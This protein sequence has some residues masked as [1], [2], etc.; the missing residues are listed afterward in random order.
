MLGRIT[1]RNQGAYESQLNPSGNAGIRNNANTETENWYQNPTAIRSQSDAFDR[2]GGANNPDIS[3][4]AI[5]QTSGRPETSPVFYDGITTNDITPLYFSA[6]AVTDRKALLLDNFNRAV[7]GETFSGAEGTHVH[8]NLT[9]LD[10]GNNRTRVQSN[11]AN[12]FVFDTR[13]IPQGSNEADGRTVLGWY[14]VTQDRDIR[15][16]DF[17]FT[18]YR[19]GE[20]VF[21]HASDAN[22]G[23]TIRAR[24]ITPS[25]SP[26]F[27][28]IDIIGALTAMPQEWLDNGIPGNWL[29]VDEDGGSLIPDGTAKAYKASRKVRDAYLVLQTDDRGVTWSDVTST[30]ETTLQGP[31]NTLGSQ[32]FAATR[33]LM[34]FY[35]TAANPFELTDSS[36]VLAIS[37]K[38]YYGSDR[39]S[40]LG[41]TFYSSLMNKITVDGVPRLINVDGYLINIHITSQFNTASTLPPRHADLTPFGSELSAKAF[42]YL[43]AGFLH[44]FYKEMRYNG[45]SWGDDNRFNIVDNQSTVTDTNGETVIVGQKLVALPYHFDGDLY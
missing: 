31:G 8:A 40:G 3:T 27:L 16:W 32:T 2:S 10:A 7:A 14:N 12:S 11:D 29:A 23:D 9:A 24:V 22:I 41:S 19:F 34:I 26:Q 45:T 15:I 25:A 5:G 35:R 42:P 38:C 6:R 4:G 20:S 30:Y 1:R 39:N 28:S 37:E 36:P 18:A 33:S 17:D 44:V 43:A 21:I 13:G